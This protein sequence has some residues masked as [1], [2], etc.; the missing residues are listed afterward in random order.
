MINLKKIGS[1]LEK[2]FRLALWGAVATLSICGIG[3]GIGIE[4]S[5]VVV[6]ETTAQALMYSEFG[7]LTPGMMRHIEQEARAHGIN[8]QLALA[9]VRQESSG[10]PWLKS[11]AGALGLMQVMPATAKSICKITRPQELWDFD[12]NVTCGVKVLDYCLG[13]HK[14]DVLKALACYNGSPA[15]QEKC[16]QEG[17]VTICR[18]NCRE[19]FEYVRSVAKH[20]NEIR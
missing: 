2:G 1:A 12:T 11:G 5:R 16:H 15:C 18:H 13:E 8:P 20:F 9:V 4:P 3:V 19:T 6:T 7:K 17:K 14:G 10:D